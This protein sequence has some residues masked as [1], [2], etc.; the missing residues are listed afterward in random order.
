MQVTGIQLKKK[1]KKTDKNGVETYYNF[2]QYK[3][4]FHNADINIKYNFFILLLKQFE[5]IFIS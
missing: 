1:K 5:Y 3:N 2:K 4:L